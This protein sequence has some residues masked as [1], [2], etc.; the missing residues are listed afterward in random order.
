MIKLSQVL[1]LL[2]ALTV[3]AGCTKYHRLGTQVGALSFSNA[4]MDDYEPTTTFGVTYTKHARLSTEASILASS[5]ESTDGTMS[6]S[7]ILA[8]WS[9]LF[10]KWR[11]R[12]TAPSFYGIAGPMIALADGEMAGGINFGG[13]L[14]SIKA[15]WDVRL[16]M[17]L[18]LG[19]ENVQ[20][21]N[22]FSVGYRF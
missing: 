10:A 19:S 8:N 17:T 13:G 9:Y 4:D 5:V 6:S 18:M 22:M 20:S 3:F 11:T 2:F 7:L 1:L 12:G 15:R 16:I 14:A 21:T